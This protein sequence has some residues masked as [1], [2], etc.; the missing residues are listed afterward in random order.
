MRIH[1]LQVGVG[2][3]PDSELG[4]AVAGYQLMVD[5]KPVGG[6]LP[7]SARHTSISKLQPGQSMSVSMVAVASDGQPIDMSNTVKVR[8]NLL[9][10]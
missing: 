6:L 3:D 7:K 1:V 4:N 8:S 5:G 10:Y 9:I 2:W